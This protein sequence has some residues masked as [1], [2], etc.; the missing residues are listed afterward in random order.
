MKNQE[1]NFVLFKS[2]L[3]SLSLTLP[4]CMLNAPIWMIGL[5]T[6][7][8]FSPL[9]FGSFTYATFLYCVYD[10]VRPILYIWA[11]VVTIQ[12][13]QDFFAKAFYVLF[14]IQ[15]ITIAKRLIGTIGIILIALTESKY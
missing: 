9:I 8:V 3:M 10:I 5:A 6:F 2:F 4:L 7:L 11:L 1:N 13:E 14:A 15:V 12:G